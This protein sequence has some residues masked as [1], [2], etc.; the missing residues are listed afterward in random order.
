MVYGFKHETCCLMQFVDG[1]D[2]NGFTLEC[3]DWNTKAIQFYE[4]FGG[5]NM[6]SSSKATQSFRFLVNPLEALANFK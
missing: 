3:L 6:T 4:K 2:Y 5:T 1:G